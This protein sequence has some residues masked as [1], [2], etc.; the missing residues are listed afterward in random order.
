MTDS[1][2]DYGDELSSSETS[3]ASNGSKN[4]N[5]KGFVGKKNIRKQEDI[6]EDIPN[7]PPQEQ[8]LRVEGSHVAKIHES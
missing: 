7:K 1:Y 2:P 6:D 3:T 4:S 5:K 8:E